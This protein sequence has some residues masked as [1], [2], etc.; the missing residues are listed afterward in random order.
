M[1]RYYMDTDSANVGARDLDRIASAIK[2]LNLELGRNAHLNPPPFDLVVIAGRAQVTR[3]RIDG[4]A[5]GLHN[6]AQ[7][8]ATNANLVEQLAAEAARCFAHAARRSWTFFQ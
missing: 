1:A 6:D 7:S 5:N 8:L 3:W 2:N 4:T